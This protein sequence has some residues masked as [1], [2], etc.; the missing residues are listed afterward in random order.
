MESVVKANKHILLITVG[1][2]IGVKGGGTEK[3][4]A[5]MANELS[6]RGYSITALFCDETRGDPFF[7]F[8]PMVNVVNAYRKTLQTLMSR[9]AW[10]NIRAISF[11]KEDRKKK[12][13]MID[14]DCKVKL[15]ES[16]IKAIPQI[17]LIVSFQPEAT[18]IVKERLGLD[19][20]TVSMLH[21]FP[22]NI[23]SQN[24]FEYYRKSLRRSEVI[25]VLLP[26]FVPYVKKLFPE[27]EVIS[28]GNVAPNFRGN[29]ARSDS[30]LIISVGRLSKTK[31][32]E[33]LIE[34]FSLLKDKFPTWRCEWWGDFVS[35]G[36][37]KE[38]QLKIQECGLEGRFFLKGTTKTIDR[39]LQRASIFAFPTYIEGFSLAMAEA[40]AMG[41][42]IV[43]CKDCVS[44]NS[45]IRDK[46]NGFLVEPTPTLYAEKLAVLMSNQ[47]LR[48]KYGYQ[49][50]KDMLQ[51]NAECIWGEWDTLLMKLLNR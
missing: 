46:E 2:V 37:L 43:G 40:M 26:S 35:A 30:E 12:R 29:R 27:S 17:D 36:V 33:L 10:K 22:E 41:L 8:S 9:A 7:L 19:V 16:A 44:L 34:A 23:F 49:C 11:K 42:P 31:R 48:E 4:F 21:G 47:R 38:I 13:M 50:R 32:P 18:Y 15:I 25:Q 45:I 51:Y 24:N 20:C 1:P 39:E 28:I 5:E 3:V 6:Q 14:L